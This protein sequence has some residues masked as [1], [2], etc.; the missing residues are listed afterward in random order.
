MPIQERL[1]RLARKG[2]HEAG[3]RLRQIHAQEVHLLAHP[4][5]HPDRLAKVHL[6]MSRWVGQRHEGLAALRPAQSDIV[7]HHRVTAAEAMLIAQ[8]LKN[9]LRRMPLLHRRRPIR[10]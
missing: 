1:G 10:L 4:A 6:R 8:P 7:F 3:V 2:L 5:D 9:P